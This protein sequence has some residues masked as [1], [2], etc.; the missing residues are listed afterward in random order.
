MMI[1]LLSFHAE[2]IGKN[3]TY[4]YSQD[5]VK[6]RKGSGLSS[7]SGNH[8]YLAITLRVTLVRIFKILSSPQNI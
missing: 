4:I 5:M 1:N 2:I 3:V 6:K 7:A 8:F